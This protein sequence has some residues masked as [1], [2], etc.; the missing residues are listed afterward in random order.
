MF[1]IA[2][3]EFFR[4][5]FDVIQSWFFESHIVAKVFLE[6]IQKLHG[7]PKVIISDH[8]SIFPSHFW[9]DL[10]SCLGIQLAHSSLYHPQ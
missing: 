3:L 5:L 7:T 2:I 8:D 9:K 4:D 6:N 10:F 1:L